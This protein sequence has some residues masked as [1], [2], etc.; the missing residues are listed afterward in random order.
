MRKD[1]NHNFL[2][3]DFLIGYSQAKFRNS[4]S[5]PFCFLHP[6][7][8]LLLRGRHFEITVCP[9]WKNLRKLFLPTFFSGGAL[10]LDSIVSNILVWVLEN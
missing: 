1:D 5:P 10:W 2:S 7:L 8:F 4:V 3:F 6:R 9:Q